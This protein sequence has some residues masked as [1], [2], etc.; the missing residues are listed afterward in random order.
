MYAKNLERILASL[1]RL[2]DISERDIS[3][4]SDRFGSLRGSE[5]LPSG[6]ERREAE[7]SN[8]HIANAVLGLATL[9]P[10]WAALGATVLGDL[11]PVGGNDASF[12]SAKNLKSAIQL[13]LSEKTARKSFIRLTVTLAET[14]TNSNGGAVLTYDRDGARRKVFFV[15]K[16]ATSLL[17]PGCE[18]EFDSDEDLLNSPT[19]REMTFTHKFFRKLAEELETAKLYRSPPEGDGSEYNAEEATQERNRKLGARP[20]SRFMN[21]GVDNQ[22]TWPREATQIKFDRYTLVLLPKTKDNVQSVHIDLTANQM[23]DRDGMTI[24]NRFLSVMSW[25]DDNFAIAQSGW[26]GNPVPVAVTKRNL[27]FTT[28]LQYAFDR[29]VPADDDAKRALALYREARNAQ[30]N[31]LVSYAVLNFY[32]IIEM[33]NHGKEA[34]RKWFG[35][36]FDAI[37]K[38][39]A[40][41]E[42]VKPFL[43][44]CGDVAPQKYIHDSCRLAVAHAGR[45]SRSD[46]DDANEIVRLHT[47]ASVMQLLARRFIKKEFA[48]S[49]RMYSG[50]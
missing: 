13:L 10:G 48:I 34:V 28:A 44:L 17:M 40:N 33:R 30:Q 14:G 18:V 25:C 4:Y 24:V 50:N 32:K 47:A 21:I 9:R 7:L 43:K 29:K 42:I 27:A 3:E 39:S 19:A 37:R 16:M 15:S 2:S 1:C 8:A 36:N 41:D 12:F 20:N 45:R 11:R 46:P 31:G 23:S 5:L 38:N 22:V 6:R 35:E 26:S 49:D